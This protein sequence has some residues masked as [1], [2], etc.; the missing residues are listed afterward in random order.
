M[1]QTQ[2]NLI[3][4]LRLDNQATLELYDT[5]RA[6]IGD[7]M[8]VS[9]TARVRIPVDGLYEHRAAEKLPPADPLRA[10]LGDPVTW[11]N[12]KQRHFIDS[13]EKSEV[14]ERLLAE[15]NTHMRPYLTHP[16]F[17]VKYVQ[18]QLREHQKRADWYR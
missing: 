4:Q 9:L 15:F 7:R 10:L 1:N 2:N 6:L 3:E 18:K 5:S 17:P 14:L 11:E 16:D 12:V 13:R 8:L